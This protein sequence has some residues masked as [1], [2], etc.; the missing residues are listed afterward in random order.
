ME[1]NIHQKI[2]S[3]IAALAADEG[4]EE[5]DYA[6]ETISSKL[7]EA[8]V[9]SA[10]AG[11]EAKTNGDANGAELTQQER[12]FMVCSWLCRKYDPTSDCSW[13]PATRVHCNIGFGELVI[14]FPDGRIA[15]SIDTILPT[16][17]GIV[18]EIPRVDFDKSL[19]W[20]GA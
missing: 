11:S 7:Q 16:L 18:K 9:E 10:E 20:Q 19:Y 13:Q 1:L 17:I 2:L 14:N 5:C 3:E 6:Q 8:E 4:E 12:V 15:S